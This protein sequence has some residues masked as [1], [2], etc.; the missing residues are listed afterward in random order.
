MA[1]DQDD[2]ALLV[3]SGSQNDGLQD[4][5]GLHR[6]GELADVADLSAQVSRMVPDR[7]Q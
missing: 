6:L 5:E 2:A 4:A 3:Q 1:G 7:I